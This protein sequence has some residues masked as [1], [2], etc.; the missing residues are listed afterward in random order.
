MP[1]YIGFS[2]INANLPRTSN[3]RVPGMDNGSS[4]IVK[5]FVFGKKFRMTDAPLVVQDFVNALNIRRGTK[6]G[7]PGYGTT[8]WDFVFEPNSL[9][10]QQRL[11]TE[12][13]R[14]ASLDPRIE[15]NYVKA[16]TA[17]NG[18]SIEVQMSVTPF[19]EPLTLSVLFDSET[20]AASLVAGQ[21]VTQE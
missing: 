6:V 5:P 20:K 17:I 16:F 12:I 19:N 7:Q 11:E 2:T 10:T 3:P 13:T 4:G 21:P 9:E 14:V 18:I 15:L 8:L 1:N